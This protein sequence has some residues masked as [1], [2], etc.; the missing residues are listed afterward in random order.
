MGGLVKNDFTILVMRELALGGHRMLV[1]AADIEDIA[2]H[3]EAAIAFGVNWA[4]VPFECHA[5]EAGAVK[6]FR[7]L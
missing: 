5:D 1:P 2:R 3:G 4:V 6:F 7:D